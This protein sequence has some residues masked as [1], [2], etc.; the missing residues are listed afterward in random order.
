MATSHGHPSAVAPPQR[1][2]SS[3]PSSSHRDDGNLDTVF[4]EQRV[5]IP[6]LA[7]ASPK[8]SAQRLDALRSSGV[9][10]SFD[11]ARAALPDELTICGDLSLRRA[12]RAMGRTYHDALATLT[13]S[14]RPL[15]VQAQRA[16]IVDR[17]L[18]C[19][20]D[21]SCLLEAILR[22]SGQLAQTLLP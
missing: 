16:W 22:R 10:P 1:T 11:C 20:T 18:R 17:R 14:S 9:T 21:A 13:P 7:S 2:G 3:T 4:S 5:A 8:T 6:D 19:G 12:D 15:L